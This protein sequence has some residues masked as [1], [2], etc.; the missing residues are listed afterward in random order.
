M[1]LED[2]YIL[3]D[4]N[5]AWAVALNLDL[6]GSLPKTCGYDFHSF[7]LCGILFS[8][9][10]APTRKGRA[11]RVQLPFMLWLYINYLSSPLFDSCYSLAT[12]TTAQVSRWLFSS[13]HPRHCSLDNLCGK[14]GK[15]VMVLV[16]LAK[17]VLQLEARSFIFFVFLPK[18]GITWAQDFGLKGSLSLSNDS[19]CMDQIPIEA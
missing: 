13:Q 2:L 3:F 11:S 15:D 8:N 9:V 19:K 6:R 14:R 4:D 10:S 1:L 16:H 18:R 7:L 17:P 5:K 12:S